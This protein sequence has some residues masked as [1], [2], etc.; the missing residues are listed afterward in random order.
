MVA[1]GETDQ[2]DKTQKGVFKMKKLAVITLAL[3]FMLGMVSFSALGLSEDATVPVDIT[4]SEFVSLDF[5]TED[6]EYDG[7]FPY[8]IE[9]EPGLYI[10]DGNATK[11]FA[12]DLWGDEWDIKGQFNPSGYQDVEKFM[13]DANTNVEI[14]LEADFTNWPNLPTLFRISSH[15]DMPMD[16]QNA[17]PGIIGTGLGNS[18]YHTWADVGN[19]VDPDNAGLF[20]NEDFLSYH[21]DRYEG[22]QEDSFYLDFGGDYLSS[23]PAMFHINGALLV[24]K[25]S[26]APAG[27]YSADV[28]VTVAA[29]GDYVGEH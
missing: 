16:T 4:I 27:E 20:A 6:Y 7:L 22:R 23:G 17:N 9:G 18:W 2:R 14:T 11:T 21:N 10:S 13:V 24:P 3:V 28:T 8:T 1:N 5:I 19:E 25:A 15:E 29:T 26:M 12:E